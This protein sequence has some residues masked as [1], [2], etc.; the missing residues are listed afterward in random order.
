MSIPI[1]DLHNGWEP[2]DQDAVL[3][4][5]E[6]S[7]VVAID[8]ALPSIGYS[9][10][11]LDIYDELREA[12]YVSEYL[13]N[14]FACSRAERIYEEH[15][16]RFRMEIRG[17]D[18]QYLVATL[19]D[20]QWAVKP[21]DELQDQ[22]AR[23]RHRE[24]VEQ[25]EE[26]IHRMQLKNPHI[27]DDFL[28]NKVGGAYFE[29]P[30]ALLYDAKEHPER[31]LGFWKSP[32]FDASARRAYNSLHSTVVPKEIG[33]EE[34][35]SRLGGPSEIYLL[36]AEMQI[37]STTARFLSEGFILSTPATCV[38]S[39]LCCA[40]YM[41][42]DAD[43]FEQR[44]ISTQASEFKDFAVLETGE[45]WIVFHQVKEAALQ[46]YAKYLSSTADRIQGETFIDDSFE[47]DWTKV[48]DEVFEE[49][50][51]DYIYQTATF[52]RS[53]IFKMGKSRSRDG[54]RDITVSTY[55]PAKGPPKKFIFQCKALAP[56][57]SLT[58]SNL[59]SVSDV[60]EQYGADGYGVFTTGVMDATVHDRLTAI[61]GRRKIELRTISR[62]EIERF[63]ARRPALL[64]KYRGRVAQVKR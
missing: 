54:G 8:I 39:S 29:N 19:I 20:V 6:K 24:G 31:R 10:S 45:H 63:L 12:A 22:S 60:I 49:I 51:Y 17:F 58:T 23:D 30:D 28:A 50:C 62:L 2:L 25:F 16:N 42:A 57:R 52:D 18:S 55:A 26:N 53:T 64:A 36:H 11:Y 9:N 32:Y 41:D 59:G 7:D 34:A 37:D 47:I 4:L 35:L 3:A 40:W 48:D 21:C 61:T 1:I 33:I 46:P 13:S 27:V 56:G 15:N 38:H 5:L 44:V 43:P 14:R